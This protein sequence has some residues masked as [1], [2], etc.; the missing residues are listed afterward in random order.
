MGN[1][2]QGYG[3]LLDKGF[4]VTF[5]NNNITGS[6]SNVHGFTAGIFDVTPNSANLYMNNFL[7][8]NKCST[9]NNSNYFV[10]FNPSDSNSLAFPV[11]KIMNGKFADPTTE[12]DNIVVEYSQ[13]AQFYPYDYLA[14][15]P[16]APDFVS[17]LTTNSIWS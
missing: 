15:I 12:R 3:V 6:N 9:F 11:K 8:G 5:Q 4:S 2:G 16:V 1:A 17:Y 10:P 7:E 14:T 13:T